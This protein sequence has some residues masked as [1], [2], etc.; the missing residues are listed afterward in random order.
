MRERGKER[1]CVCERESERERERV[2]ARATAHVPRAS[3]ARERDTHTDR[4]LV[5][6]IT[7]QTLAITTGRAKATISRESASELRRR[8]TRGGRAHTSRNGKTRCTWRSSALSVDTYAYR[9]AHTN[10]HAVPSDMCKCQRCK[11]KVSTENELGSLKKLASVRKVQIV[12]QKTL[13][14]PWKI[15]D[16]LGCTRSGWCSRQNTRCHHTRPKI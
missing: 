8:V 9:H 10:A 4:R 15:A 16:E 2:R 6:R 7:L 5:R 1:E 12:D 11:Y 13:F 3:Q 14:S